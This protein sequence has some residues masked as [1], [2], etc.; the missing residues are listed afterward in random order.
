MIQVPLP[1][2]CLPDM[3]RTQRNVHPLPIQSTYLLGLRKFLISICAC[4]LALRFVAPGLAAAET[5]AVSTKDV[6]RKA[7]A[8]LETATDYADQERIRAEKKIQAQFDEVE[9]GIQR[10]QSRM[11]QFSGETRQRAEASLS[12]LERRKEETRRK[13]EEIKTA[14]QAAWDQMR[15][16]LDASLEELRRQYHRAVPSQ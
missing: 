10:L 13:L 8:A 7:G 3:V 11:D 6:E 15:K 4:L 2:V 1:S 5:S 16:S 9:A 12:D 14:G